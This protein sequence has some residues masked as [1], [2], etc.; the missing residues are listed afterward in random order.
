[1]KISKIK[2]RYIFQEFFSFISEKKKWKIIQKIYFRKKKME[3][4][5]KKQIFKK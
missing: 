1:M 3:N 4:N 2:S 5:S